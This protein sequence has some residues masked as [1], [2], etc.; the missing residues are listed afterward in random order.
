MSSLRMIY[1]QE[2]SRNKRKQIKLKKNIFFQWELRCEYSDTPGFTRPDVTA[3]KQISRCELYCLTTATVKSWTNSVQ[4]LS[5]KVLVPLKSQLWTS[6]CVFCVHSFFFFFF[7]FRLETVEQWRRPLV[8]T[9]SPMSRSCEKP[10]REWVSEPTNRTV[11][12][13]KILT[14]TPTSKRYFSNL[15]NV[16][17]TF[18]AVL[19]LFFREGLFPVCA[20]A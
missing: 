4:H 9:Q 18:S 14:W 5:V 12:K 19:V 20:D 10:W 7:I 2:I 8:L 3:D 16:N 17:V 1:L 13:K 15:I 6:S 11:G